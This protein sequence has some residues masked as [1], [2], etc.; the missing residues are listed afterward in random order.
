MVSGER[1]SGRAGLSRSVRR[2]QT[3]GVLR[4]TACTRRQ[5]ARICAGTPLIPGLARSAEQKKPN[6][7]FIFTDDQRGDTI[8]ALGDSAID[9]SNLDLL[10]QAGT[11][12]TDAYCMAGL[13]AAACL[14][15]RIMAPRGNGWFK[16][17]N[18]P[19]GTPDFAR[20]MAGTGYT[21]YHLGKHGN[22][23][24]RSH[25]SF[26]FNYYLEPGDLEEL[27]RASPANSLPTARKASSFFG[28]LDS[29]AART[30]TRPAP[31]QLHDLGENKILDFAD[32][33][34]LACV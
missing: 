24:L 2:S 17:Q 29:V 18:Q 5:F 19:A 7:L 21:T 4:P 33:P 27:G 23:D 6:V 22:T 11:T 31:C 20:S 30:D 3:E 10:V 1:I 32:G 26:D 34:I 8:R 15:S 9:P 25:R 13:S 14:P 16:A 12:F 28:R